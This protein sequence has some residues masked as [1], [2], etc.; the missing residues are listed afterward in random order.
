MSYHVRQN[1]ADPSNYTTG[2][3]VPIDTIII[4][5]AATT[6]F[7]GIGATFRNPA[8][9][10]SAHYGVGSNGNVDQYVNEGDTAWHAGNWPVNQRSIGIENVNQTG[11][12]D[13]LVAQSTFNTLIELVTDIAK[14]HNLLPLVVGGN[15]RKGYLGGHKDVSINPTACPVTLESR[16]HELAD[17]VNGAATVPQPTPQPSKPDQVLH[18]GEKFQFKKI[19]TVHEMART[20]G[21][22]Q[23][24]THELCPAG[25]SWA[26]N[27]LPVMPLVEVDAK[28]NK[29]KDQVLNVGSR[30]KIPGTYTVLNLGQY[31]GHWMAEIKMGGWRLWVD[32]ATVTEV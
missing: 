20:G 15:L 19:Y 31:Q 25:F 30:Y 17:R 22:W 3:A 5:H 12:P 9:N 26:D 1:P 18:V 13:W 6:D 8:R 2:R 4:H 27:G 29:T 28:G 7:N 11:A 10:A 24:R 21:I 23:V 16:L 14:R 32:I